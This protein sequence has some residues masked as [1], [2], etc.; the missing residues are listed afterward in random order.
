V[1]E[2]SIREFRPGDEHAFRRLNEEWITRYFRLEPKDVEALG[3]PQT[4]IIAKGGRIFFAILDDERV[5]CCALLPMDLDTYEVAKMAVTASCQGQ[6]IGRRILQAAVDAARAAGGR[7][8]W[9]ETNRA[10]E[11]ALR[12]YESMGFRFLPEE[13]F[14]PSVYARSDVQ[15]EMLLE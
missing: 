3:T 4:S 15:M 7:R 5:G 14:V 11:P 12:L 13:R 8:V 10:M 6:G 2:V 9:L 1:S